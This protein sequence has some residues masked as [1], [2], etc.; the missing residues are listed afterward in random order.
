[1][2]QLQIS[3]NISPTIHPRFLEQAA[4]ETLAV[5]CADREADLT[6]LLTDDDQ[7]CQLNREY[8]SVDAPTDVLAFPA[9]YIDPDTDS[10]YLGDVIISYDRAVAQAEAS[11]HAVEQEIQLLVVHGI[12]H[13]LGHDHADPSQKVKMWAAQ[14]EILTR[15][16]NPLSP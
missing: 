5:A 14:A 4:S 3:E 15:L 11:G 2:I 10:R 12:L 7:I 9:D 6:I 16:G 1:M 8:L 13:L